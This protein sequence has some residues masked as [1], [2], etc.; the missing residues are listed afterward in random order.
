MKKMIVKSTFGLCAALLSCGALAQ[1]AEGNWMV[2]VRALYMKAANQSTDP[3]GTLGND[4]IHVANRTFPE[5]DI[6]YFLTRH[7]AAE[8]I[9]TYPQKHDV[10]LN[11]NKIGSF[12]HL[13]PTLMLQYHFL[14]GSQ[15]RL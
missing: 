9:L 5:V 11:G 1:Q 3:T 15:F 4:S 2:R 12:K 7:L 10:T 6:S 14:P 13:P 8:L